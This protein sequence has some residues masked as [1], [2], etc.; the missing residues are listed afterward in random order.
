MVSS[1]VETP[2][3]RTISPSFE[4]VTDQW[5]T[6]PHQRPSIGVIDEL[7]QFPFIGNARGFFDVGCDVFC[8][9]SPSFLAVEHH[10]SSAVGHFDPS[11][12]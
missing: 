2:T 10:S 8:L 7:L 12:P 6:S 11:N 3:D 1:H 9:H 5:S 4:T